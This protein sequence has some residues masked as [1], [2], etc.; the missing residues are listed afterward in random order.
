MPS[1]SV[2]VRDE[3]SI[4]SVTISHLL[5]KLHFGLRKHNSMKPWGMQN[6]KMVTTE[7]S[8]KH[9]CR[10][11]I[12]QII[13]LLDKQKWKDPDFASSQTCLICVNQSKICPFSNRNLFSLVTFK[14][15][16]P[17]TTLLFY[18][19]TVA[20]DSFSPTRWKLQKGWRTKRTW[21]FLWDV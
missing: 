19:I 11:R 15:E 12:Y 4:S 14:A 18:V 1:V 3:D 8:L 16:K 9:L 10:P 5:R 2:N 20:G 13:S 17:D 7:V 21:F 6:P